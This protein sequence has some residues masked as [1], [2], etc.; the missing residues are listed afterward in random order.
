MVACHASRMS[1]RDY[2]IEI[3]LQV[4]PGRHRC[5]RWPAR[6]GKQKMRAARPLRMAVD[7]DPSL[8]NHLTPDAVSVRERS[9]NETT[10]GTRRVLPGRR[11]RPHPGPGERAM[12]V[13]D[14]VTDEHHELRAVLGEVNGLGVVCGGTLNP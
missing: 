9:P 3:Y 12:G 11:K 14:S 7:L 6:A 2:Q 1:I 4:W 10:D 13:Y 5:Y 8:N